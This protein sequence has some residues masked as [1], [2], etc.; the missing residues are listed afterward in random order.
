MNLIDQTVLVTGGCGSIGSAVVRLLLGNFPHVTV[1]VFN[2]NDSNQ[3][4]MM[5]TLSLKHLDRVRFILGDVTDR[6]AVCRAVRGCSVVFHCAALKHVWNSAYNAA[7]IQRVNVDGTQSVLEALHGQGRSCRFVLLST[8]KAVD[9]SNVMGASKLVAEYVTLG[10]WGWAS[11]IVARVVRLGNV[12][13]S[14]GSVFP[15]FVQRIKDGLP[16]YVTDPHMTRY[17]MSVRDAASAMVCAVADEMDGPSIR[18]QRMRV[19]T[20]GT[21]AMAAKQFCGLPDYSDVITGPLPGEKK[22]ERLLSIHE[23]DRVVKEN[24]NYVAIGTEVTD[25]PRT[26]DWYEG[27]SGDQH[28]DDMATADDLIKMY[29]DR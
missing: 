23:L 21:M 11:N 29:E 26:H 13:G 2:R 20:V 17:V 4:E 9:P 27:S 15:T 8:D 18:V 28:S 19:A 25:S 6:G 22:H 1:R 24:F 10:S 5:S 16:I 14:R 3:H 7:E 12:F